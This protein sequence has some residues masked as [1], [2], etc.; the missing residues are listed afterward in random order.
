MY[1]RLTE[2]SGTSARST[3]A[4]AKLLKP[5]LLAAVPT[6]VFI[7]K[8]TGFFK[9]IIMTHE[10]PTPARKIR[11]GAFAGSDLP[12]R[13]I[14]F[15]D[16]VYQI[17]WTDTG[18]R[19]RFDE[20]GGILSDLSAF[21]VHE[22]LVFRLSGVREVT[23]VSFTPF[24][25][26]VSKQP[27]YLADPTSVRAFIRGSIEPNY[28]VP[29]DVTIGKTVSFLSGRYGGVLKAV[30]EIISCEPG[31]PDKDIAYH[32]L[33][34]FRRGIGSVA[35]LF[36]TVPIEHRDGPGKRRKLIEDSQLRLTDE[37]ARVGLLA[38]RH[39]GVEIR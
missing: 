34:G 31:R 5:V 24:A 10:N 6:A 35:D 2:C 7:D 19:V 18:R 17:S 25:V 13:V 38:I 1:G 33:N 3:H 39:K 28:D 15:S 20:P 11:T 30:V 4:T 29:N 14:Q 9:I 16:D 37:I 27:G 36:P 32:M 23:D 26:V 12:R 22:A 21:N 8:K